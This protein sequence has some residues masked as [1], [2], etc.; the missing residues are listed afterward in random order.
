MIGQ[1]KRDFTIHPYQSSWKDQFEQE[2]NILQHT[3]GKLV[4][5]IEH[6]GSTAVPGIH[7]KAIIDIMVAV[8]SLNKAIQLIPLLESLG[9]VYRPI[10]TVPEG[11]YFRKG[12][13]QQYRTHH[14]NLVEH[15]SRFWKNQLAF[16]DYLC[17]HAHIAAEYVELKRQIAEEFTRTHEIDPHA[18]TAFVTK[19][20]EMADQESGETG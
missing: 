3:L 8:K 1:H 17:G 15:E 5:R 7:A 12:Q 6:I 16:R 9:Y 2:A 11:M 13:I 4:L 18:K 10:D 14:L 19:V 20:L